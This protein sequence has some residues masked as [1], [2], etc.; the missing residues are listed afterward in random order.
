[1]KDLRNTMK[2]SKERRKYKEFEMDFRDVSYMT[3]INDG[4]GV[5][6]AFK[7]SGVYTPRHK[8]E[9]VQNYYK[10]LISGYEEKYISQHSKILKTDV[11]RT[12]RMFWI[13]DRFVKDGL[14]Y[15][16]NYS[17]IVEFHQEG[18]SNFF[19]I[20]YDCIVVKR[21]EGD[22]KHMF[23]YKGYYLVFFDPSKWKFV[24]VEEKVGG[25]TIYDQDPKHKY[26]FVPEVREKKEIS[27]K[28]LTFKNE[29]DETIEDKLDDMVKK[30][31]HLYVDPEKIQEVAEDPDEEDSG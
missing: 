22:F 24:G 16:M 12:S 26:V 10:S 18:V 19:N 31:N 23:S 4:Y 6:N 29:K 11:V 3:S 30:I 27:W 5:M 17:P 14:I 8:L 1:M 15:K 9:R 21:L 20:G 2:I 7:S 28:N 25:W 13:T